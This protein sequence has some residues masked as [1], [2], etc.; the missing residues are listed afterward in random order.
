MSVRSAVAARPP[1]GRL[2]RSSFGRAFAIRAAGAFLLYEMH[3][4]LA[5]Y[6][7]EEG[8]GAISF[9]LNWLGLAVLVAPLGFNT[10]SM[11]F[12]AAYGGTGRL[13]VL[14]RFLRYSL[15]SSLV[16]S[17]GA[18]VLIGAIGA[19]APE[20][21]LRP[22]LARSLVL[23][24]P[25]VAVLPMVD[26]LAATQ[27]GAG[28]VVRALLPAAVV[29]PCAVLAGLA[30]VERSGAAASQERAF[31]V[32]LVGGSAALAVAVAAFAARATAWRDDG[33]PAAGDDAAVDDPTSGQWL[34]TA[35]RMVPSQ[36][37]TQAPRQLD[38]V[39]LGFVV[40]TSQL[41]IYFL[42][43]RLAR[44]AGFGLQAAH[45]VVSPRFAA[46]ME[47]AERDG[48]P[49]LEAAGNRQAMQAA[50]RHGIR[51]T[52]VMT[53]PVVAA[54]FVLAEWLL[55]RAGP[56]FAAD[57]TRLV[58]IFLIGEA[59]NVACGLNGAFLNMTGLEGMLSRLSVVYLVLHL[60]LVPIGAVLAGPVGAAVATTVALSG[61]NLAVSG[62]AW[63]LR[64]VDTTVLSVLRP[65]PMPAD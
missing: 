16:A 39:L 41:G 53:V 17:V 48:D 49:D 40:S 7:G 2:A 12:V 30:A 31:L 51:A 29:Y 5:D 15:T 4:G 54:I 50:V 47:R 9:A 45:L 18:A 27:R 33:S 37:A 43:S 28:D 63:R 1:L 64:G 8:Y 6:A 55:G 32:L 25:L 38:V 13:A 60:L 42:A 62:A 10:A 23:V 22:E 46:L 21:L 19:L 61:R 57:G 20:G 26:V 3:V 11:R 44:L 65:Q 56:S 59:I 35:I 36:V 24:A 34:R 14:R 58:H 52:M